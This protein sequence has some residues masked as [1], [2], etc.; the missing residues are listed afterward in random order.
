M[1]KAYI[2]GK[3]YVN[4][5]EFVQ[6]A[7]VV[8]GKFSLVGT[9]AEVLQS[10]A[11][12]EVIDLGGRTVLPG[13]NDSHMHLYNLG[14]LLN[15][16]NL[17]G[18]KSISD[19]IAAGQAFLQEKNVPIGRLIIGFLWDQENFIDEGRYPNRHDLDKISK[20][21]PIV[22]RRSCGHIV[23]CNSLALKIANIDANTEVPAGGEIYCD[24]DGLPNGV[25]TENAIDLLKDLMA[26]PIVD[27]MAA[28]IKAAMDYAVSHGI[29]SVQTNDIRDDN[30]PNM[31]AAYNQLY[32]SNQAVL[33]TYHQCYFT[34]VTGF[35]DFIAAGYT[36][37]RGDDMHKIGPLKKFA[38]GSLGGWTAAM[39]QPYN[40]APH[41]KGLYTL[42][43]EHLDEMVQTANDNQMSCVVHAIGD[44]AMDLVLKSFEKVITNG[45]NPN[46]HGIIHC[47]ITDMS[48]L[49]RMRD[50]DVLALVQ[51]IFLHTDMKMLESRVGAELART[52]YAWA[53]MDKL[54]IHASYGTDAPVEDISTMDNLHCAVN[55]Q[56][57]NAQPPGGYNPAECVSLAAAIDNYTVESAYTSFEEDKKGRIIVGHLADMCVLDKDIFTIDPADIRH[58]QVKMTILGGQI[59]YTRK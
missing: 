55:R 57:L 47:Q 41:T 25:L 6:A 53:T 23:S 20:H 49:E 54:G 26:P 1:R 31:L 56:D 45:H 27:E 34:D 39:R 11:G 17:S 13:F 12:C 3:F 32:D 2:N 42:T 33:R 48:I 15:S 28:I 9:T 24:E 14:V 52:S 43:E 19:C 16:L 4:E 37:G 50:S 40:D 22:A 38:D 5:G 8:D 51:P 59:V 10:A 18:C 36:T 46:R 30:W 21:H 44:G 58:V 29:T 35:K 7:L